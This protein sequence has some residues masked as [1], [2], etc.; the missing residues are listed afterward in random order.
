[1]KELTFS[2]HYHSIHYLI[3]TSSFVSSDVRPEGEAEQPLVGLPVRQS[4][5]QGI[6][7]LK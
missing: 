7:S 6:T 1:M 4:P 3:V 5:D 2:M